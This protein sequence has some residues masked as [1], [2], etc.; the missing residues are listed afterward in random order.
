MKR[1]IRP[2]INLTSAIEPV[3]M[4][5]MGVVIGGLVVSMYLADI[6][7]G[8]CGSRLSPSRR[9]IRDRPQGRTPRCP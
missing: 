7:D 3:M 8:R 5:F 9:P 4:V 2:W 6:Q 1:S